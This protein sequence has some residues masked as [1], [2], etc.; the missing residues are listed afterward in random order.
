MD[1]KLKSIILLF[2]NRAPQLYTPTKSTSVTAW[3]GR[4]KNEEDCK[5]T[6]HQF[7]TNKSITS[8]SFNKWTTDSKSISMNFL[9]PEDSNLWTIQSPSLKEQEEE[10]KK[11][12][13]TILWME[14]LANS[15]IC[16]PYYEIIYKQSLL[17]LKVKKKN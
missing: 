10:T 6:T 3:Q 9:K 15:V 1:N 13:M 4:E 14:N 12:S 11:T 8:T 5:I 7:F 16:L 17:S 2:S